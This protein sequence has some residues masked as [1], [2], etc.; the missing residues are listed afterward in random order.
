LSGTFLL[1]PAPDQSGH[2]SRF[3]LTN[4]ALNS[5]S[6]AVN[7]GSGTLSLD[8]GNHSQPL[9]LTLTVTINGQPVDLS[10]AGSLD[11][12]SGSPPALHGVEVSGQAGACG[13]AGVQQYTLTIFALPNV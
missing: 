8:M 10:G 3:T 6:Y 1:G 12:F 13:V 11:T 5:A 2:V 9:S 7:D 4:V